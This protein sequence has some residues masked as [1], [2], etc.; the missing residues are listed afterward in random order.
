MWQLF[1]LGIGHVAA[2]LWLILWYIFAATVTVEFF[3][4]VF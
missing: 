3:T 1:K 4:R 2:E